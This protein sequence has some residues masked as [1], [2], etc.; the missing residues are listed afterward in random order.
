MPL[1]PKLTKFT[2]T[3]EPIIAIDSTNIATGTSYVNTFLADEND[4]GEIITVN[5]VYS[6]DGDRILNS[7]VD[8][9][10]DFDFEETIILEGNLV[11]NLPIVLYQRGANSPDV[12]VTIKIYHV[13]AASAETQLG[14]TE[15]ETIDGGSLNDSGVTKFFLKRIALGK[16]IF[17][18]GEKLRINITS[19]NTTTANSAAYLGTD[20]KNRT[21]LVINAGAGDFF[22]DWDVSQS[23]INLPF[24][25]D[26]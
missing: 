4:S 18:N 6:K 14:A 16:Q 5:E 3:T 10:F 25:I 17:Q 26:K 13:N 19:T 8:Y 1:D 9:D 15:T 24:K 7:G 11:V 12:D 20:P 21:S 2:T 23:T 22:F